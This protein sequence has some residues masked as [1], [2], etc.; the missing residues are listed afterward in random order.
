[1]KRLIV[2]AF[3][4]SIALIGCHKYNPTAPENVTSPAGIPPSV[5]VILELG[6]PIHHETNKFSAKIYSLAGPQGLEDNFPI[7][8]DSMRNFSWSGALVKINEMTSGYGYTTNI[9][10]DPNA[11]PPASYDH[12]MLDDVPSAGSIDAVFYLI[13][14]G[15]NA[16]HALRGLTQLFSWG[17]HSVATGMDTASTSFY[18]IPVEFAD[19]NVEIRTP[20][21][22]GITFKL[23]TRF[24]KYNPTI[25]GT[26]HL[27]GP[28]PY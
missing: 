27:V 12:F 18:M 9:P 15:Q 4:A 11:K 2:L 22:P 14:G 16:T 7:P 26:V 28:L 3:V 5:K 1:M 25:N 6:L 21:K 10:F 19:W 13:P 17:E 8:K 23:E 24:D 20:S